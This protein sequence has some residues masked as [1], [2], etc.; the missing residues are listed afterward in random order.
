MSVL[1]LDMG[2]FCVAIDIHKI[3]IVSELG[4][5]AVWYALDALIGLNVELLVHALP[6]YLLLVPHLLLVLGPLLGGQ[7][8][9]GYL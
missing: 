1:V 8:V 3:D 7:Q 4:P 9:T 6:P 2:H 5:V